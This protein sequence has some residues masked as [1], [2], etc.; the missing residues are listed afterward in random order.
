MATK[1]IRVFIGHEG[2]PLWDRPE[3]VL[4]HSILANTKS[5]VEFHRCGDGKGRTG[6]STGRYNLPSLC[7]YEGYAIHLDVDMMVFGDIKELWDYRQPGKWVALPMRN[8]VSV[9]DCSAFRDILPP[10]LTKNEYRARMNGPPSRY[11]RSLPWAWGQLD[12]DGPKGLEFPAEWVPPKD[13]KLLHLSCIG[14]QP[15]NPL[16]PRVYMGE[17]YIDKLWHDYEEQMLS[18]TETPTSMSA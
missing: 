12:R 1:P 7:D 16:Y 11:T 6:F 14:L 17:R 15:W 2:N 4:K 8:E 9:I 3:A 10:G 18:E 5:K 13:T